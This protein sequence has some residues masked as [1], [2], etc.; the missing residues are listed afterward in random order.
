[1]VYERYLNR[2]TYTVTQVSFNER[3]VEWIVTFGITL[4]L[5]H[6]RYYVLNCGTRSQT[7]FC[8]SDKVPS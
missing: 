4:I 2:D 3:S 6:D 7:P 1:M 5:C 8:I